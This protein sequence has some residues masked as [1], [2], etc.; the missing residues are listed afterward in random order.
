MVASFSCRRISRLGLLAVLACS[1][2]AAES[3]GN[4][5]PPQPASAPQSR[6]A[7]GRQALSDKV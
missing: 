6:R 5:P 3:P 2:A 7:R 1:S 4:G